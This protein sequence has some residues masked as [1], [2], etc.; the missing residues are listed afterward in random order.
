M[1]KVNGERNV[2]GELSVEGGRIE[3]HI[4]DVIIVP[5]VG[6]AI[7]HVVVEEI[8]NEKFLVVEKRS[9]RVYET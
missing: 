7:G 4:L 2:G 5:T 9:Y 8:G 6:G 3:E 1:E